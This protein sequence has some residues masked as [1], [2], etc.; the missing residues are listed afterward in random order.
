MIVGNQFLV[1]SRMSSCD[2]GPSII[3]FAFKLFFDSDSFYFFC[4]LFR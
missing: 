3:P 2:S 4:H 1:L